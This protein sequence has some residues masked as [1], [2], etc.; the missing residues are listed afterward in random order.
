MG[1]TSDSNERLSFQEQMELDKRERAKREEEKKN[2]KPLYITIGR[3]E[4]CKKP[5][6]LLLGETDRKWYKAPYV[7]EVQYDPR[8]NSVKVPIYDMNNV[9]NVT[10]K[11]FYSYFDRPR[12]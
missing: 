9:T 8:R 10:E 7:K 5:Y 2:R 4:F 3:V 12:A 6:L 11:E 1:M